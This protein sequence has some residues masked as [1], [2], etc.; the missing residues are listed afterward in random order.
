[1]MTQNNLT[2]LWH[3]LL[4]F[5]SHLLLSLWSSRNP[6][7]RFLKSPILHHMEVAHAFRY[8]ANLGT[9][10]S[11][12]KHDQYLRAELG[13]ERGLFIWVVRERY[14]KHR[15]SVCMKKGPQWWKTAKRSGVMLSGER[16]AMPREAQHKD[17]FYMRW[18]EVGLLALPP[19]SHVTF[20]TQAPSACFR[21]LIC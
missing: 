7:L 2:Q 3:T 9:F 18:I 17:S 21:V 6:H 10:V 19:A 14:V 20:L 1:M 16:N 11:E 13:E 12:T 5:K 4:F 8:W 15:M